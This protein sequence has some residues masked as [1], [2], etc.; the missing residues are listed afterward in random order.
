VSASPAELVL[1]AVRLRDAVEGEPLFPGIRMGLDAG[2]VVEREGGYFGAAVNVAARVAAH[3]RPGQV[4]CTE[5]V[6]AGGAPAGVEYR[7]LG[8]VRLRNVA[9]PVVLLEV[10]SAPRADEVAVDPVCRMRVSTVDPPARLPFGGQPWYFCSFECAR[11][12]VERPE[13]YTGQAT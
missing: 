3:A 7:A 12:F 2:A 13:D 9:A 11:R 4:L 6:A 1:T 5:R 10:M 8:P